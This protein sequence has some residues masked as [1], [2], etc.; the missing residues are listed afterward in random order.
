MT[1]MPVYSCP[2]LKCDYETDR[3]KLMEDHITSG[4]CKKGQSHGNITQKKFPACT[5]CDEKFTTQKL[6]DKHILQNHTEKKITEENNNNT[7]HNGKK[8]K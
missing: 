8:N 2:N 7:I 3:K 1:I 6:L 4:K 5:N